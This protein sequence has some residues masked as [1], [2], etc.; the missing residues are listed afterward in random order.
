MGRPKKTEGPNEVHSVR[1]PRDLWAAAKVKAA[2]E[3]RTVSAVLVDALYRY[4][5][6][7]SGG[8]KPNGQ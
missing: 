2:S 4:A 8:R 1:V 7:G 6:T 5:F 3:N